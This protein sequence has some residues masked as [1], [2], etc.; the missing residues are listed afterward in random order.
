[1]SPV[2]PNA[3]HLPFEPYD[4]WAGLTEARVSMHGCGGVVR[5]YPAVCDEQLLRGAA[6]G[7]QPLEAAL[8]SVERRSPYALR[9]GC[10]WA[11]FRLAPRAPPWPP[12]PLC[13]S[14]HRHRHRH[15]LTQP[16]THVRTRVAVGTPSSGHA[17]HRHSVFDS[18]RRED[19]LLRVITSRYG[20]G[21]RRRC[22]RRR[23]IW[24]R[25]GTSSARPRATPAP[26]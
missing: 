26:A 24:G 10:R 6:V 15:R 7:K 22:T 13:G 11:S 4:G 5:R 17:Q 2:L 19:A 25:G 14:T 1:M 21:G 18:L 12:I 20:C 8:S 3:S 16:T 23:T 9:C